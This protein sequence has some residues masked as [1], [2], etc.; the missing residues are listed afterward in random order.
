MTRRT[1][2]YNV[3]TYC[4]N[5]TNDGQIVEI[6]SA[7]KYKFESFAYNE[8]TN[9]AMLYIFRFADGRSINEKFF[10]TLKIITLAL[11][12]EEQDIT[13]QSD[14]IILGINQWD[15]CGTPYLYIFRPCYKRGAT[16]SLTSADPCGE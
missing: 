13:L 8:V 6:G 9:Q 12:A 3:E 2:H 16:G 15:G 14:D 7:D 5:N 11:C 1:M 4:L 10:Y